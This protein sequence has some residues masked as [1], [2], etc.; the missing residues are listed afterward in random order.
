M[1]QKFIENCGGKLDSEF[2]LHTLAHIS[3]G[4]SAGS[5]RKACEFVLTPHRLEALDKRPL[6]ATEFIGPLSMSMNTV[7]D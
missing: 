3:N 2:P 1:W 5:I 6:K 7:E 4:Y